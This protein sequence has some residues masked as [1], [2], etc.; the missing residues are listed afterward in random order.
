M[1]GLTC[2]CSRCGILLRLMHPAPPGAPILCVHC[3]SLRDAALREPPRERA[4]PEQQ[5]RQTPPT[6][7]A[8]APVATEPVVGGL[9][10]DRAW[11]RLQA[12]QRKK[13][14]G[15]SLLVVGGLVVLLTI[16][17]LI[18]SAG[19]GSKK[20]GRE[21][22][23]AGEREQPSDSLSPRRQEEEDPDAGGPLR[24]IPIPDR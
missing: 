22:T 13:A 12:R 23:P 18:G 7:E 1:P 15:V 9:V 19:R 3:A 17:L 4:A 10:E 11:E 14:L 24:P 2:N 20:K 6:E 5:S 8:P 16:V 21:Q